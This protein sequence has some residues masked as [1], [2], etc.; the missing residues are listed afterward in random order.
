MAMFYRKP[1]PEG[2]LSDIENGTSFIKAHPE[3]IG[4]PCAER[5]VSHTDWEKSGCGERI[6]MFCTPKG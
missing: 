2:L 6:R 1:A 4:S 5:P 3:K